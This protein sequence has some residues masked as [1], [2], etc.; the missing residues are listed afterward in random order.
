M[1]RRLIKTLIALVLLFVGLSTAIYFGNEC[2]LCYNSSEW[3]STQG[4]IIYNQ[5][6]DVTLADLASPYPQIVERLP[7]SLRDQTINQHVIRYHYLVDGETVTSDRVTF[8]KLGLLD[9]L[10]IK[11]GKQTEYPVGE[12]VDLSYDPQNVSSAVIEP[13]MKQEGLIALGLGV[14]LTIL[15]GGSLLTGGRRRS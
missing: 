2:L 15:T 5:K 13:G 14:F 10:P 11:I 3:E 8:G 7:T 4:R 1:I 6:E 12:V 9:S